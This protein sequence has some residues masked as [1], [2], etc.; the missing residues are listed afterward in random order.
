MNAIIWVMFVLPFVTVMW[1]F[2]II[3]T[4][5]MIMYM[6]YYCFAF[7]RSEY[8]RNRQVVDTMSDQPGDYSHPVA[9]SDWLDRN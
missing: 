3:F 4:G 6:K 7:K 1:L 2:D 8:L 5:L 9:L